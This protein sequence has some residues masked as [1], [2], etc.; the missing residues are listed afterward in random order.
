MGVLVFTVLG[1][2]ADYVIESRN[3]PKSIFYENKVLIA[4]SLILILLIATV[5]LFKSW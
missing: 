4:I 5:Y 1:V 2:I 3:N